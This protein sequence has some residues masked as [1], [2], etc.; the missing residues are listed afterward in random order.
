MLLIV[1]V[2]LNVVVR[3]EWCAVLAVPLLLSH[4]GCLVPH[5][6]HCQPTAADAEP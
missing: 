1:H 5:G 2:A 3:P 4:L 6:L